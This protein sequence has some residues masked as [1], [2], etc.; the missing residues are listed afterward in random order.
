MQYAAE[1]ETKRL[2]TRQL[3]YNDHVAWASFFASA[4]ATKFIT[5]FDETDINKI[6]VT[7]I[8][9]QQNRYKSNQGGLQALIHKTTGAFIGQCGLLIQNIDGITELEIGYHIFPRFWGMGYAT[10]AAQQFKQHA[11]A[12]GLAKSV[13]SIIHK[14]NI[15]SQRVAIKNGMAREKESTFYGVGVY[16]YRALQV[17]FI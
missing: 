9:K 5:T 16:V 12:N 15:A 4:Q 10:E 8:E 2:V 1:L 11:F 6:A 17:S 14:N 3:V 13:I 7:W